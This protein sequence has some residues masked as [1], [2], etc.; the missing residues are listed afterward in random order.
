MLFKLRLKI[1]HYK[2]TIKNQNDQ[3]F[4]NKFPPSRKKTKS[5]LRKKRSGSSSVGASLKVPPN[6]FVLKIFFE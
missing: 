2:Y 6:H 3:I 1:A 4:N 5:I